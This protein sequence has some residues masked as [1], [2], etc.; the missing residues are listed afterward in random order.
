MI[1]SIGARAAVEDPDTLDFLLGLEKELREAWRVAITG[2]RASGFTDRQIGE[3][4]GTSR[5]AVEQR[6]PHARETAA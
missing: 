4:L 6:W 3:Q 1:K 2:L 5:Q